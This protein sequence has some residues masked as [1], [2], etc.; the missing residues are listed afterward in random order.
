MT[1]KTMLR[2]ALMVF[3]IGTSSA[4][5]GD[6][7]PKDTGFPSIPAEQLYPQAAGP[8]EGTVDIQNGA[9]AHAYSTSSHS[10]SRLFPPAQDN[11]GH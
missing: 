7:Q 1:M 3:S 11:G 5:T 9:V 6:G 2:A 8:A 10:S 4:H